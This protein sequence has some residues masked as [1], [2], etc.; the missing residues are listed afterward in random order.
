M[1]QFLRIVWVFILV[2]VMKKL[3]HSEAGKLG[4]LASKNITN[5]IKKQERIVSYYNK[6]K[7][8]KWCGK[9]IEY[10]KHN[11]NVFCSQSCATSYNNI[12]RETS[13]NIKNVSSN[14]EYKHKCGFNINKYVAHCICCGKQIHYKQKYCS[15]RC[16]IIHKNKLRDEEI[17]SGLNVTQRKLRSYLLRKHNKCMSKDCCWDWSKN[18]NVSLEVHH[19]DGDPTNNTLSNVILLCPNCHSLTDTYKAKNT[20]NGRAF[21]RQ[22]YK[23]GKSY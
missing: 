17:E 11:E 13:R 5:W 19:L 12:K 8:C 21:R 18:A 20:G 1:F 3:S 7:L 9:P 15:N 4:A 14:T 16:N 6:P 23:E 2:S 22:R 10:K